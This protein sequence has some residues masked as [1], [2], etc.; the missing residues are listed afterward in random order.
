MLKL[1]KP[2]AKDSTFI[3]Y[4]NMYLVFSAWGNAMKAKQYGILFS[5]LVFVELPLNL[6]SRKKW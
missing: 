4:D 6:W 5:G 3:K 2:L 1:V